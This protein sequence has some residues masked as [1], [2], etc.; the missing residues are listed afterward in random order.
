MSSLPNQ[1]PPWD[2]NPHDAIASALTLLLR[3]TQAT[4]RIADRLD[5]WTH[6]PN[7]EPKSFGEQIAGLDERGPELRVRRW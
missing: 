7:R 4:E 6:D 5:S 2:T 1:K 3:L